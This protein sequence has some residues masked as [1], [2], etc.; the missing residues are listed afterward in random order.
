MLTS[1]PARMP[2][3]AITVMMAKSRLLDS[4]APSTDCA[5]VFRRDGLHLDR[6]CILGRGQ[7]VE[8]VVFDKSLAHHFVPEG[9]MARRRVVECG[10][11]ERSPLR[12]LVGCVSQQFLRARTSCQYSSASARVTEFSDRSEANVGNHRTQIFCIPSLCFRIML[13]LQETLDVAPKCVAV[14]ARFLASSV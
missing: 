3:V 1:S 10:G 14:H 5:Q 2:V 7:V 13:G 11:R 4:L 8:R 6:S 9:R 12:G